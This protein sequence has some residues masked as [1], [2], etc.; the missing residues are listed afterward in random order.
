MSAAKGAETET[1]CLEGLQRVLNNIGALN[2]K[3]FPQDLQVIFNELGE[4]GGIPADRM[5][6]LI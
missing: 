1:V 4:A 2:T 3:I 6:K 5:V